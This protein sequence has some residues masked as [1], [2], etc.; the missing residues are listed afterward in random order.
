MVWKIVLAVLLFLAL[1]ITVILCLPVTVLFLPDKS[2]GVKVLGRLLWITV[3][4]NPDPDSKITKWIKQLLN[5]DKIESVQAVRTEVNRKGTSVTVSQTLTVL[6]SLLGRV[7]FL[8]RHA[9]VK[10]CRLRL[11]TAASDAASAAMEYGLACS[12]IYPLTGWMADSMRVRKNAMDIAVTC[13]FETTSSRL[14]YDIRLTVRVFQIL[15]A[16]I[17]IIVQSV[18]QELYKEGAYGNRKPYRRR[19]QKQHQ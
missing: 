5:I 1:L 12:L 11:S 14:D 13:D 2:G 10:K 18:N 4:E 19:R 17:H 6:K 8:L 3:G 15:R 7:V 9:V 16:M